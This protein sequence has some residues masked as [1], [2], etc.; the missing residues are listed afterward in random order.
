[1]AGS[2]WIADLAI[3]AS[4]LRR[5]HHYFSVAGNELGCAATMEYTEVCSPYGIEC[6]SSAV[7]GI[8]V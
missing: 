6:A 2:R 8:S 5:H 3:C 4:G 1:V 7:P